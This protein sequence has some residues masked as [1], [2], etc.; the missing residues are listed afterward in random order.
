M[1]NH[2]VYARLSNEE[3]V[4]S[5]NRSQKGLL[6]TLGS[7]AQATV[8]E[9]VKNSQGETNRRLALLEDKA[10]LVQRVGFFFSFLS[11]APTYLFT[12]TTGNI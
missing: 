4:F 3:R 5:V 1:P 7:P 9:E 12:A 2:F 6:E 11:R 8:L 10:E